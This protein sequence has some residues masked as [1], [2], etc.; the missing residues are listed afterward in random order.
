MDHSAVIETVSRLAEPLCREFGL[1]LV[2]V[3]FRRE[4]VGQVLRVVIFRPE[5]VTV[6]DCARVSRELGY[7][8]DVEDCI[9]QAYTLEVT[10]PGLDWPLV[11]ERDFRRYQGRRVDV[12][13]RCE[14]GE[15][16]EVRGLIAGV[17]AE[18]VTVRDEGGEVTRVPL[19]RIERA[20]LVIEF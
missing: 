4:A 9:E 15:G 18:A 6:D 10:S 12:V 19:D 7:L 3:Q 11:T 5:G 8:L 1:E 14:E 16:R 20:R 2:A 17:T 13:W